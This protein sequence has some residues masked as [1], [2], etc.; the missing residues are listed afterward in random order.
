M[1]KVFSLTK[2]RWLFIAF[3]FALA[4]PASI[5]TYKS[6]EQLRW[7][8][9]IQ[10][11]QDIRS[12][13]NQIDKSI[14]DAMSKEEARPDTD[15]TFFVLAGTPEARFVQR[16]DLSKYPV[17][18]NFAGIIGYFQVD[19]DGQYSTPI[20]PSAHVQSEVQ[21]QLYGISAQ[22]N[23]QRNQLEQ[24]VMKILSESRWSD[25]RAVSEREGSIKKDRDLSMDE[26]LTVQ[27]QDAEK[28]Q[29][30]S[31]SDSNLAK[32]SKSK[33]S[34]LKKESKSL[35][36]NRLEKNYSPQQS[37][38]NEEKQA[39]RLEQDQI[40][41]NLFESEIE[42][43]RLNLLDDGHLVIYRYVWRDNKRLI[44]GA[45]LSA[46]LFAE[47][48]IYDLFKA[49]T[50]VNAMQI[51]L[52]FDDQPLLNERYKESSYRMDYG[53][54]S[55]TDYLLKIDLSEPFNQLSLGFKLVNLPT[56]AGQSFILM[57]AACL[58]FVLILGTYFLYR[59]AIRQSN[60]VQQQQD[61]VSSVSHELKT[62]LTSIRMYGEILKQGWVSDEKR[63]E[64]YDYIYSESERLSRLIANVLQISK[65]NHNALEL[66]LIPHQ[67][68][69]LASLIKSKV[70]SQILQSGF[71]LNIKIEDDL[72][73]Q[74]LLVDSD[75]FVQILINLVDN[76]IKYAAKADKKQIN[77][78]FKTVRNNKIEISVRDFGPGISKNH[79]KHIFE[80]FYR[81]G[82]ELTRE[83]AG[84]G[85]GLALVKEL[86][87]AMGGNI[88]AVNHQKGVEFIIS[89]PQDN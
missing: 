87:L 59:V 28:E 57:T 31:I 19:E 22:E 3:F 49:S 6:Y 86:C 56:N 36:K 89:F 70:D 78:R 17:E 42:P 44:Q 81:S 48:A 50:L 84:T 52:F 72:E 12:L 53:L 1:K 76:A 71:H 80:L 26:S 25:Q 41:I 54:S 10:Y 60:L 68:S 39:K 35:R 47:E 46:R 9:L 85:I 79:M 15:Y 83:T 74:C 88:S 63:K 5:L 7:Q 43:F 77:I 21:P 20:L 8:T 65:V 13:V 14:L 55:G 75:A 38:V 27:A 29:A 69:E 11:Q 82:N 24:Q 30:F 23:K 67:L 66:T 33:L 62:P 61:F 2:T 18:S 32:K 64:Y 58:L 4:I 40:Q 45:V 51:E 37:L 73:Q 34:P 16:S